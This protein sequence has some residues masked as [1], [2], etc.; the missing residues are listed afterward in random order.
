M[1]LCVGVLTYE[2]INVKFNVYSDTPKTKDSDTNLIKF[3]G[4]RFSPQK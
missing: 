2:Q 1:I 4:A 3:Y